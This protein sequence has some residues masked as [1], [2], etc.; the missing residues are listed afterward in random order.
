VS[1]VHWELIVL[2]VDSTE[3]LRW[4]LENS[5]L[6]DEQLQRA[7]YAH[8]ASL[9]GVAPEAVA[10]LVRVPPTP[11][12]MQTAEGIDLCS[13]D[14]CS[15]RSTSSLHESTSSRV[16][17]VAAGSATRKRKSAT[18]T[19]GA[20]PV[21]ADADEASVPFTSAA[22]AAAPAASKRRSAGQT[23]ASKES[24]SLSRLAA[25][26][27]VMYDGQEESGVVLHGAH[28]SGLDD[29]SCSSSVA[30]AANSR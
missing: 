18:P 13:V 20:G 15:E 14:S 1:D 11:V 3:Y 19:S 21:L 17:S 22:A 6:P 2:T 12:Q 8:L 23:S 9:H 16:V 25:G 27:P 5:P 10:R 29:L 7:V 4:P 28:F 30:Q 24:C 26:Q